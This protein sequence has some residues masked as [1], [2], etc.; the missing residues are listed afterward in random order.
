MRCA[1][2][3]TPPNVGTSRWEPPLVDWHAVVAEWENLNYLFVEMNKE[4]NVRNPSGISR[5][6]TLW[7]VRDAK[8]QR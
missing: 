7:K 8:G 6:K 1:P 5:A 2:S 3:S 4:V